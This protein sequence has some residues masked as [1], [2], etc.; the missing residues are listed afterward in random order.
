MSHEAS[1]YNL[2]FYIF[3]Y[4]GEHQNDTT[5]YPHHIEH[6]YVQRDGQREVLMANMKIISDILK[7]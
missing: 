5:E 4:T 2:K 1:K 7:Q 6:R 3:K